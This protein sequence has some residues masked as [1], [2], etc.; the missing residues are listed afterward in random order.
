[1]EAREERKLELQQFIFQ[2]DNLI[3]EIKY[4]LRGQCSNNQAEHCPLNLYFIS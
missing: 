4:K 3:Q 1:M 2:G